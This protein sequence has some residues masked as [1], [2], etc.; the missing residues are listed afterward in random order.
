MSQ[1]WLPDKNELPADL[2][3]SREAS[4]ELARHRASFP[5]RVPRHF[6]SLYSF[7]VVC[8]SFY[9]ALGCPS[10]AFPSTDAPAFFVLIAYQV[11]NCK[12]E[13]KFDIRERFLFAWHLH[14]FHAWKLYRISIAFFYARHGHCP[15]KYT[16]YPTPARCCRLAV[17]SP[18]FVNVKGK[19]F[20]NFLYCFVVQETEEYRYWRHTA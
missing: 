12:R 5:C 2:T 14:F 18:P 13:R 7:L 3:H 6:S 20:Q 11:R 19:R 1:F 4:V 16:I 10:E 9:S 17:F 15:M 8:S